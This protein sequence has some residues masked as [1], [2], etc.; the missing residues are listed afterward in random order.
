MFC[1]GRDF[2]RVHIIDYS[3][4]YELFRYRLN[5]YYK[6]NYSN[7]LFLNTLTVLSENLP[8]NLRTMVN[9]YE[10]DRAKNILNHCAV[11]LFSGSDDYLL[12]VANSVLDKWNDKSSDMLM[13]LLKLAIIFDDYKSFIILF[14]SCIVSMSSYY[15]TYSKDEINS[16]LYVLTNNNYLLNYLQQ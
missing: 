3:F 10:F 1:H 14:K 16:L 7:K 5:M 6:M 12:D 13:E 4:S 8:D 2:V 15:T 11:A 9:M